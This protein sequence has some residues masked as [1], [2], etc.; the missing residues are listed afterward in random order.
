MGRKES[1]ILIAIIV[2]NMM[3]SQ[4]YIVLRVTEYRFGVVVIPSTTAQNCVYDFKPDHTM[5]YTIKPVLSSHSKRTPT[6]GFQYQLSHDEVKSIAECSKGSILEH[7]AILLTIIKLPF[8]I[9]TL[10][11]S[12]L[13]GHLRQV[14]L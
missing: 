8:S 3:P 6:N 11:L 13:I 9:K 10:V 5:T 2:H 7:S 12:I 14:L 1:N 4:L